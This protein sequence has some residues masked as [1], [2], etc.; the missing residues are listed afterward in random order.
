M[1]IR[2]LVAAAALFCLIF[3]SIIGLCVQYSGNTASQLVSVLILPGRWM[4]VHHDAIEAISALGYFVFSIALV[5]FTAVL[6]HRT[7]DLF[8]ETKRLA[9]TNINQV[10]L[11]RAEFNS[12][13]APKF[14]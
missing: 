10:D 5:V 13:T 12:T 2:N 6:A 4:R 11:A 14:G 8:R 3:I 1:L 7:T 9:E